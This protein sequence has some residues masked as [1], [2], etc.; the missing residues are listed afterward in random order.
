MGKPSALKPLSRRERGWGEGSIF[1]GAEDRFEHRIRLLQHVIVPEAQDHQ[2]TGFEELR[3]H[4]I[5]RFIVLRTIQFHDQ[6]LRFANEIHDVGRDGV[7]PAEFQAIQAA[8]AKVIPEPKFRFRGRPAQFERLL[9]RSCRQRRIVASWHHRTLSPTP[10]PEG[11]GLK[12]QS[13][14]RFIWSRSMLS[15]S[16]WKLPSPKPSLPLRWMISKKIGPIAF[17][18]KICSSR[19]CLVSASASI[20]ILFFA[21]RGTSSPWLGMRRSITSK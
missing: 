6:F 1:C 3:A 7:L 8:G 21:R 10:P 18:V 17:W 14:P 9:V 11:E 15:N 4:V 12:G 13:T 2:A 16:A 19:R 20:R 5:D